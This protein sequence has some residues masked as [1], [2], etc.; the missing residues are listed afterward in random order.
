MTIIPTLEFLVLV[1]VLWILWWVWTKFGRRFVDQLEHV[2][3][4]PLEL[5]SASIAFAEKEF[6]ANSPFPV[7]AIVD[8]AYRMPSGLL[9]LMELKQ[10][11]R[12]K[13]FRS[14][15]VE[16]SVQKLAM[17][18]SGGGCVASYAYVVVESPATRKKTA[19]KVDLM[20]VHEILMLRSRHLA[21]RNGQLSPIKVDHP[22]ICQNCGY[23]AECKPASIAHSG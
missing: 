10:R 5:K 16:L 1:L 13:A 19:I 6:R 9:I 11:E 8:R 21:L 4:L 14:D 17:E 12:V 15:I 2:S 20:P 23:L 18:A 3:W 22:K 7:G